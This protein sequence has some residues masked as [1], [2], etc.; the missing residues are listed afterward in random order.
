MMVSI[1]FA[2]SIALTTAPNIT[3]LSTQESNPCC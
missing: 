3:K 1:E 2:T